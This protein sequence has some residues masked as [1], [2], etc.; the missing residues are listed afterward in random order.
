MMPVDEVKMKPI[1]ELIYYQ[2]SFSQMKGVKQD[3]TV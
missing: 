2:L 1:S 3:V